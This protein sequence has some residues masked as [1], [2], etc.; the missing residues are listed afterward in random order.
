M[1]IRSF[2]GV[3][4]FAGKFDDHGKYALLFIST[5]CRSSQAKRVWIERVGTLDIALV[6]RLF[7]GD[8]VKRR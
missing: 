6:W 3:P 5:K 8:D 1:A 7:K 2:S 4:V